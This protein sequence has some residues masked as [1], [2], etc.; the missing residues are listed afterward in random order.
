M[1][2][3]EEFTDR[4]LVA[5]LRTLLAAYRRQ[6]AADGK[7]GRPWDGQQHWRAEQDINDL[8]YQLGEI[9]SGR[10]TTT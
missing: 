2:T 5:L 4:D 6:R 10:T 8:E 9:D 1:S 7:N 3:P